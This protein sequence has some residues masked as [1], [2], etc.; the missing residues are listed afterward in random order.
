MAKAAKSVEKESEK[1]LVHPLDESDIISAEPMK[2]SRLQQARAS[3]SLHTIILLAIGTIIILVL[4]FVF[5]IQLL[6]NFSLFLGKVNGNDKVV[7][8]SDTD[9]VFAAPPTLTASAK[10]V[11]DPSVSITANGQKD[12]EIQ[13]FVNNSLVDKKK[14][15]DTSVTFDK[16]PL[17]GGANTITAKAVAGKHESDLSEP[18]KVIYRQ[19]APDLDI[20]TP[21]DGDA[22][23]GSV[24]ILKVK[25]KTA[26]YAKVTVNGAWTIMDDSGTFTYDY[27]M[28]S[29]DNTI[30]VVSTD[31][32]G[33]TTEKDVKFTYSP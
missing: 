19:K 7:S 22:F 18:L 12:E 27:H 23:S 31:E 15:S 8:K 14:V 16:V 1:E 17:K 9:E 6:I 24:S 29:G 3:R 10:V 13:L 32:A 26:S 21:K 30:K 28:Q 11:K 33:N 4:F 25:G 2:R 20:D 5:G